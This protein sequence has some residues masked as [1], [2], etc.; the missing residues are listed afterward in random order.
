[1]ASQ[2]R[3]PGVSRVQK[4]V[5]GV[6]ASDSGGSELF[7]TSGLRNGEQAAVSETRC[8]TVGLGFSI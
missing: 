1:M 2:S 8:L 5:F 3:L 4:V 7:V 6:G